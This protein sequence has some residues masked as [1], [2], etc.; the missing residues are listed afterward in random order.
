MKNIQDKK[1]EISLF[2]DLS[3]AFDT[4]EHEVIFA[5]ME[6]IWYLR[7]CLGMVQELF[8]QQTIASSNKRW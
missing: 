4:L 7:H 6:K 3:K 2:L 5:K 1:Y 8:T